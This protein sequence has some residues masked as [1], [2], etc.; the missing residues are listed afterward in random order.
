MKLDGVIYYKKLREIQ[1][2][3]ISQ[4]ALKY[5]KQFVSKMTETLSNDFIAD[6]CAVS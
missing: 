1:F 2:L 4:E 5:L 6:L 3:E